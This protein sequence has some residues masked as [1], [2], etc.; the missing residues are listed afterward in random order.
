MRINS[1]FEGAGIGLSIAKGLVESMG[2]FIEVDSVAGKV[3]AL[4][5][6]NALSDILLL[7]LHTL[8]QFFISLQALISGKYNAFLM[9]CFS[10]YSFSR[11]S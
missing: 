4:P 2:G 5:P 11:F 3:V 8:G 6:G 1:L 9:W 7:N 10:P